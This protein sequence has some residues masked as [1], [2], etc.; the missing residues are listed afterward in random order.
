PAALLLA[1]SCI[2]YLW[3]YTTWLKRRS[4]WGVLAG[5]IPG[6]LPPL[7]GAAAAGSVLLPGPLLLALFIFVWQLPHFWL[8]ALECRNQYAQAG[9]PV[10]PL[11]HGAP[12]TKG[13]TMTTALLLLPLTVAIGQ[14]SSL[15]PL[16]TAVA[17]CAGACFALLCCHCLYFSR[18][19]R[20]GFRAS[21][22]Y[23]LLLVTVICVD[24][25]TALATGSHW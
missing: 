22:I 13:L 23:L 2:T 10:L 9:V 4:P 18:N 17:A 24:S 12:L 20:L 25:M 6:A 7:I 5:G 19:Y 3:L 21:L 16:S 8:L 14:A 15:S 11:T 1:L